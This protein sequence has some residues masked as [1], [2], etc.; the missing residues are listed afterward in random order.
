MQQSASAAS[1]LGGVLGDFLGKTFRVHE[2]ADIRGPTFV[3]A[4]FLAYCCTVYALSLVYSFQIK[5]LLYNRVSFVGVLFLVLSFAMRALIV[6]AKG[7]PDRPFD[8]IKKTAI[9]DWGIREKILVGLP[10]LAIVTIFF[11]FY[12]S[13]KSA[14]ALIR[15]FYFDAYAAN[16]DSLLHGTDPWRPLHYVFGGAIPTFTIGIVYNVWLL[17]TCGTIAFSLFYLNDRRLRDR[18]VASLFL[19]WGLVG[20]LSGTIFASVGPCYYQFFYGDSRYAELMS[21]LDAI[22]QRIPLLSRSTQDYLIDAYQ[23]AVPGLGTGISAFPSLHVGTAMLVCLFAWNFGRFWK[24]SGVLFVATILVGSVHLGWHYAVD[25]YASL[26]AVWLI[27]LAVGRALEPSA[28][29]NTRVS[30]VLS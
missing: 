20:S 5:F 9:E 24:A 23:A 27:W 15:P 3:V 6:L 22:D 19:S 8:H 25:G 7:R 18:F 4:L 30:E 10:Y 11:A 16:L 1:G 28:G 2:H 14:I 29:R 13:L 17:V 21:K 26:A 12:S